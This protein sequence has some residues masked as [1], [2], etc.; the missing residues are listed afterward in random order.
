MGDTGDMSAAHVELNRLVI[1][2]LGNSAR[3]PIRQDGPYRCHPKKV[4]LQSEATNVPRQLPTVCCQAQALQRMLSR[5]VRFVHSTTPFKTSPL[6]HCI[7]SRL[8]SV[9]YATENRGQT[10]CYADP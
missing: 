2:R 10:W 4:R 5:V 7:P 8:L 9:V 1:L 3:A 6:N